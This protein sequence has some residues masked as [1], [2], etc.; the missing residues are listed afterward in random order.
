MPLALRH[1]DRAPAPGRPDRPLPSAVA[2]GG[3]PVVSVVV[4]A[5]LAGVRCPGALVAAGPADLG[6]AEASGPAESHI[7]EAGAEAR[8]A[9]DLGGAG[10]DGPAASSSSSAPASSSAVRARA[11]AAAS[12][13][14]PAS[15]V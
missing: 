10:D 12:S 8:G 11:P 4:G 3:V 7:G 1:R 5:R 13:S 14:A 6:G 2:A 9:P 15:D